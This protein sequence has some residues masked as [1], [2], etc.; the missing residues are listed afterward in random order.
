MTDLRTAAQQALEA[1]GAA[2][3]TTYSDTLY[4]QFENAITALRAAL[5][6][7]ERCSCGDRPADQCPGEWEPGCDLGNNPKHARRVDLLRPAEQPE[8]ADGMPASA[9]E[10]YLR[11]LLAVRVGIP[12]AYYDD[13]EAHGAQHGI[14]ID[15]MREPVADIDAKLRALNVARAEVAQRERDKPVLMINKLGSL[16]ECSP[17][18]AAFDLPDGE[19]SLYANPPRREWRNLTIQEMNALPEVGCRMWNMGVADAV[20]R[21]IRAVEAKLKE[22]NHH[23]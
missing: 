10:R 15:F 18:I 11:R 6:Q 7:P 12:G 1:L 3:D 17:T 13:G 9:D 4:V 14:S 22:L 8:R 23:E 2:R 19:F 21:A 5:E 20:L 16:V